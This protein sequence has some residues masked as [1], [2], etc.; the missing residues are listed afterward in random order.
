[1]FYGKSS[2]KQTGPQAGRAVL[3][4]RRVLD[5]LHFVPVRVSVQIPQCWTAVNWV[6][7]L[8]TV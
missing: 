7:L 8:G 1:M 4:L 2:V 3:Q 6:L 5:L